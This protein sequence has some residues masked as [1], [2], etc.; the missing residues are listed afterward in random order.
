[1]KP[2]S[3]SGLDDS[4]TQAVVS[5][6][7]WLPS[8]NTCDKAGA[9]DS[10]AW[11]VSQLARW[12]AEQVSC[13]QIRQAANGQRILL[14]SEAVSSRFCIGVCDDRVFLGITSDCATWFPGLPWFHVAIKRS[15][16]RLNV[17]C[18]HACTDGVDLP[19]F[20]LC[21]ITSRPEALER[22]CRLKTIDVR[23]ITGGHNEAPIKVGSTILRT[24]DVREVQG[25][26]TLEELQAGRLMT[27][28][29]NRSV[30]KKVQK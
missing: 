9:H 8:A 14:L 29:T 21:L 25:D 1:M 11:S 26:S 27:G 23:S 19:A 28:H 10:V 30:I 17:L 4:L 24:I 16:A 18:E 2:F 13:G 7:S 20:S 12:I 22:L 6:P 3:K 15:S 5:L